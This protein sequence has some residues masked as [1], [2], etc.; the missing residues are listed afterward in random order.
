MLFAQ[1]KYSHCICGYTVYE[2]R[3]KSHIISYTEQMAKMQ[4]GCFS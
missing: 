3:G 1:M 2:V 4:S